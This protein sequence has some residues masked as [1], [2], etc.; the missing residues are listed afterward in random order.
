[1][2]SAQ[3]FRRALKG[4]RQSLTGL[5]F[6]TLLSNLSPP[7]AGQAATAHAVTQEGLPASPLSPIELEFSNCDCLK[8]N[9]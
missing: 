5:S 7:A 3:A 2:M 1:M 6:D 8:P 9:E 4:I